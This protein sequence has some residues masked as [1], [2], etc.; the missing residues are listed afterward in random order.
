MH[1]LNHNQTIAAHITLTIRLLRSQ[2]NIKN[3]LT[4]LYVMIN[5]SNHCNTVVAQITLTM[6][7]FRSQRTYVLTCPPFFL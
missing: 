6:C 4:T 7:L 3:M 2:E 5:V 1:S